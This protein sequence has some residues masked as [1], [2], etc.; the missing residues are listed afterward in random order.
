[1]GKWGNGG[2]G[3]WGILTKT[4]TPYN[5]TALTPQHQFAFYRENYDY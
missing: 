2:M 4:L 5:P 3:E 1:M